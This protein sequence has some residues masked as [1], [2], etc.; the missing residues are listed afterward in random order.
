MLKY[1]LIKDSGDYVSYNYFPEG[2]TDGGT[3]TINKKTGAISNVVLAKTDKFR[4]YCNH[5][6]SELLE[7]FKKGEYK[8]DGIIAWY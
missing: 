7:F 6:V 8:S 1:K 3:V 5:M 4:R 2:R